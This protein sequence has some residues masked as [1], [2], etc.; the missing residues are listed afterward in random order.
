MA[1][2]SNSSVSSTPNKPSSLEAATVATWHDISPKKAAEQPRLKLED[3]AENEFVT[4]PANSSQT[5]NRARKLRAHKTIT[6]IV[7]HHLVGNLTKMGAVAVR[8]A[9]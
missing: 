3:D 6:D 9:L 2:E 7:P 5:R 8:K 1:D 4:R